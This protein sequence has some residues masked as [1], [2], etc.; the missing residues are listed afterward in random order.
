VTAW[1]GSFAAAK[2]VPASLTLSKDKRVSMK[3]RQC[4][5]N[6]FQSIVH[7]REY[8]AATYVEGMAV[9][10]GG[11][12]IE[13]G[14]LE[15]EGE[16]VDPTLPSDEAIYFPGLRFV[17]ERG[18]AAAMRIAKPEWCEDL[19]FFYRFGWG[20]S[21]SP[22]FVSARKAAHRWLKLKYP[23][24]ITTSFSEEAGE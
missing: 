16:I 2:N 13:H 11:L 9:I 18:I 20:G 14:W 8:R 24:A 23:Q 6:C 12:L 17:G 21:D 22:E 15:I 19:P 5:Y 10:D 4:Y 3:A 1:T 7:L